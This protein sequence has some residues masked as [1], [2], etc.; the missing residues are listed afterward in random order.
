MFVPD[1]ARE[2]IANQAARAGVDFNS[3]S[4]AGHQ[5][6]ELVL[7]LHLGL[8]ERNACGVNEFLSPR[9]ATVVAAIT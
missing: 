7:D 9:F 8:I 1:E 4:Y 6:N 2:Q 3:D 5:R